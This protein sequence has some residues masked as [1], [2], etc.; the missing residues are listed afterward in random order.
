MGANEPVSTVNLATAW[1]TDCAAPG[2][3]LLDAIGGPGAKNLRA[4][5][6]L[7]TIALQESGLAHRAQRLSNGAPGP[8]RGWWQFE[9]G[10]AVTAVLTHTGTRSLAE[11][12]CD[13]LY[14]RP[15][16]QDVWRCL[17]G[18]NELAVG[19]ARLLLWSDPKPLPGTDDPNAG[20]AYY[21]RN[22]CPGKPHP[23]Q[24]GGHWA[25]ASKA[26]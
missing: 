20:W 11:L 22:W 21:L 25:T 4:N 14:V 7:L 6:L 9:R 13:S 19:F 3:E 10:G 24:W 8:A 15:A 23:D 18:N 1:W 17:E 12:L 2:L 16:V 26:L 5:Q